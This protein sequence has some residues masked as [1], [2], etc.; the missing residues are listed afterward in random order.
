VP[1]KE[2]R[3]GGPASAKPRAASRVLRF[4]C[5]RWPP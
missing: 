3:R 4:R 5:G 1:G 2:R